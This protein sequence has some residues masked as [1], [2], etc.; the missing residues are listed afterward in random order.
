MTLA[1]LF[2]RNTKP[3]TLFPSAHGLNLA[4]EALLV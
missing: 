2:V 1:D 3:A 4:I